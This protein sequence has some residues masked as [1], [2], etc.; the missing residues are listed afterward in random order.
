MIDILRALQSGFMTAPERVAQAFIVGTLMIA[1]ILVLI[2]M[3]S[4]RP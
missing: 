4:R 3:T 2:W 1:L